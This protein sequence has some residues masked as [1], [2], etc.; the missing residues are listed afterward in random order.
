MVLLFLSIWVKSGK[1]CQNKWPRP[2]LMEVQIMQCEGTHRDESSCPW[3]SPFP[4]NHRCFYYQQQSFLHF[5]ITRPA[6]AVVK[7]PT[8]LCTSLF[9]WWHGKF[10]TTH[11][12][13][14]NTK[15]QSAEFSR[16]TGN[17]NPPPPHQHPFKAHQHIYL[18]LLH[19]GVKPAICGVQWLTGVLLLVARQP[20]T[21]KSYYSQTKNGNLID[22]FTLFVYV[23][24]RWF[25]QS[26]SDW[27]CWFA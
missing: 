12:C 8:V 17:K 6:P 7:S 20:E 22:I 5:F 4:S 15:L 11:V 25:N 9:S 3:F 10:Y 27:W 2:H 23:W 14:L 18:C 24:I 26:V 21:L 16:K 13:T 1:G 19:R